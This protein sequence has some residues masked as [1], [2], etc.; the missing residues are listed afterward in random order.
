MLVL[1]LM[2]NACGVT[3]DHLVSCATTAAA[4]KDAL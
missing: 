4:A 2:L 3:F 1:V